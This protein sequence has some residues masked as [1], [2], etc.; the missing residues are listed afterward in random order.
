RAS[1]GFRQS[2]GGD[3]PRGHPAQEKVAGR[4][5]PAQLLVEVGGA[6]ANV[7]PG[8]LRCLK[9]GPQGTQIVVLQRLSRLVPG[10]AKGKGQHFHGCPGK[11]SLL[12][13]FFELAVSLLRQQPSRLGQF[14]EKISQPL[15]DFL[16][17]GSIPDEGS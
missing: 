5:P 3:L 14:V 11:D 13:A 16:L 10:L 17:K 1:R 4:A 8:G 12:Q 6:A 15:A 9:R 2:K 7:F